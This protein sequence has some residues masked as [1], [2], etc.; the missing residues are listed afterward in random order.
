M[1]QN[2]IDQINEAA[3]AKLKSFTPLE[4][5]MIEFGGSHYQEHPS[6]KVYIFDRWDGEKDR[7]CRWAVPTELVNVDGLVF[8]N[9]FY[10]VVVELGEK[11][12]FGAAQTAMRQ[13]LGVP[14]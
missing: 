10:D 8:L 6:D 7:L 14:A 9:R 11:S 12:G 2:E 3:S 1:N 5:M 13:A 4:R